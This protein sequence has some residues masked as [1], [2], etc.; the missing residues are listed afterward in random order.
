MTTLTNEMKQTV[1]DIFEHLHA[2][3]EISW[4]ETETTAYIEDILKKLG[5]KTQTIDDCTGVI[6]E[7]GEGAPVVAVRADIDALWQEVD[8]EFKANHSCGH[9]AHMTMALGTFMALKEKERPNGTIRFI[10]QPAEER[11]GG[12]LKMI[13]KGVLADVDYLYGVHVRPIQETLNGR[14]APAILHGSSN[15]YVGTIIGEEAHGARP[16]LGINVIE[17]ASTLVQRL[18]HIHVDPR[19]AHSV[20][21]TNLHAGGG[22]SNI[23]PGKASFTLD[24]R[25][26]TNEVMDELEKEIEKAVHSVAD[27]FGASITLST[28]HRLPAATLNEEAVQIM[29]HAI[30]QVLG[31]EQLDP[32]IVTTGGEDFHF[33]AAKLPHIKSTMLG[34]GCDLKPGLHH[35]YMTFDRSAIFTGIE[36][37]TEAVYQTLQQHSS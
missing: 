2:H 6:G 3:P 12:A 18:A 14:C 10:F 8:G 26:Q 29:S 30:E 27:A 17:V 1:T 5:C 19:V 20:K 7:I 16:H 33:Y 35:P 4:E 22:S 37:L 25:A 32:P 9:D 15:H 21:M 23:I 24:V 34:L 31:K 36:I 11:G 28:D 13:E